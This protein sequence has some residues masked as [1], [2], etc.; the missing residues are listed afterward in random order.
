MIRK[1]GS[2]W[3]NSIG[4]MQPGEGYLVKMNTDDVLIYNYYP[5]TNCGDQLIDYRD[6]QVYNTVLIGEQCW[7]AENLNIGEMINGNSNQTDNGIIEKYCY[8]NVPTNCDE[9][10]G[11]YQWNEMMQYTTTQ[12]VQGICLDGWHIPTDGEWTIL[13]DFLGGESVA[14]G[15]M[16][17]LGTTHWNSPN[18]GATNE[19]GFTALPGGY[20]DLS[21]NFHSLCCYCKFWSSPEIN[22]YNAWCRTLYYL[23]DDVYRSSDGKNMSYSVRC[24]KD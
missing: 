18:I 1:I 14:G 6:G 12:G 11:L 5:F 15:K 3:V 9:Y 19:S 22:T 17:E 7:M 13:T 8:D 23:N 4:L 21:A 2:V 10:G 24:L 16:K 20:R